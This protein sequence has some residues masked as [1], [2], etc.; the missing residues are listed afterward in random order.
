M[1]MEKGKWES[2]IFTAIGVPTGHMSIKPCIWKYRPIL[3]NIPQ[4]LFCLAWGRD[5]MVF[6]FT[7]K[8]ARRERANSAL[9][10]FLS[11]DQRSRTFFRQH[12]EKCQQQLWNIN[13]PLPFWNMLRP[14]N[15]RN[16]WLVTIFVA[17]ISRKHR[18]DWCEIGASNLKGNIKSVL[19][20]M[21]LERCPFGEHAAQ[22]RC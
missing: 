18:R 21:F 6:S 12:N 3:W 13:I 10:E 20:L 14:W 9:L 15:F 19:F 1:K 11:Y 5:G 17:V 4:E 2:G 22:V 7:E 16:K 8:R